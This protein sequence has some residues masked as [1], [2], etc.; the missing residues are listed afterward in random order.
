MRILHVTPRLDDSATRAVDYLIAGQRLAGHVVGLLYTE[1]Q[2]AQS[3]WSEAASMADI[4]TRWGQ[5]Y[6]ILH[7]HSSRALQD[8]QRQ[9]Q[10]AQRRRPIIVTLHD[11]MTSAEGPSVRLGLDGL[12]LAGRIAVP[13]A[14]ASVR[15]ISQGVESQRI[16]V[17]PYPVDPAPVSGPTEQPLLREMVEWRNR[18]GDVLCAVA[19]CA[20][21][22]HHRVVLEALSML[23]HTDAA[24]C[25][26]AGIV[27]AAG[28]L[29]RARELGIQDQ[30]R[31]A[32]PGSD[33]RVLASRA[34]AVI[35][36]GFDERRPF[37]LAEVWCDGI[38]VLAGRNAQ[39][40]DLDAHGGGTLFYE[41]ADAHDLARAIATV[42][43]TTIAGRRLLVDR[44]RT[45]Y[46][47][48]FTEQAVFEAYMGEY[49]ALIGCARSVA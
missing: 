11:W 28:C 47:L 16:R 19:H 14:M 39:F 42:R 36:P 24:L 6:D 40:A 9:V 32:A 34:D 35:L 3:G 10:M 33:A 30:V 4:S 18:G 41:P 45:L 2:E 17:I 8:V 25:V 12:G 20:T 15:L 7:V 38:A 1:P 22:A 27:D 46:R 5:P 13:A 49:Q 37:A 31:I 21:G 43:N 29:Q 48:R 26:L 23:A 44:A